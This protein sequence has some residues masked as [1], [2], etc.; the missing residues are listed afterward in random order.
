[1]SETNRIKIFP[2]T[3]DRW[4]DLETLFGPR[5]AVGGCWCMYWRLK[6]SEFDLLK[7][8]G[9]RAALKDLVDEG[10]PPGLIAYQDEKPVGWVSLAPRQEFSTL[11]RSRTL[12]RVDDLPVWSVVCF[13]I[14]KNYRRQGLS[15]RLLEAAAEF[16]RAQGASILE[17]Y[18]VEPKEGIVPPVFAYT[19]LASA[20][21]DAGF[22]EVERRSATRPIMR[23]DL[24]GA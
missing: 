20:F 12:A 14:D 17:G 16:A 23:K 18:P 4:A 13:Y 22:I 11:E 15:S 5:G 19:G 21:R 1:M 8:E 24:S 6:R 9:N 3:P 7:G 2:L 10:S